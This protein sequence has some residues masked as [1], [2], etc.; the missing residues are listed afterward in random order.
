MSA[1]QSEL[2]DALS[3]ERVG[4]SVAGAQTEGTPDVYGFPFL[5][6]PS[7]F[8]AWHGD[9]ENT[10]QDYRKQS[11]VFPVQAKWRIGAYPAYVPAALETEIDAYLTGAS[12]TGVLI[13][14]ISDGHVEIKMLPLKGHSSGK[15]VRIFMHGN[16]NRVFGFEAAGF[17]STIAYVDLGSTDINEDVEPSVSPFDTID[18]KS[19]NS[20]QEEIDKLSMLPRPD[21]KRIHERL[22]SLFEYSQA[23]PDIRVMSPGSVKN[24]RRFLQA[25]PKISTPSLFL[26]DSGSIRSQ[27][28]VDHRRALSI[29]FHAS[30]TAEYVLFAPDYRRPTVTA[31]LAGTASW[32]TVMSSLKKVARLDWLYRE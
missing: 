5:T 26:A 14:T 15:N 3:R 1:K 32:Q 9:Y 28:T 10:K 23:D 30:G 17:K 20:A 7:S 13:A 2:L 4:P 29:L 6:D 19:S 21:A 8:T 31:D 27:W 25:N 18:D 16:V 24:L 12:S 22:T 11:P